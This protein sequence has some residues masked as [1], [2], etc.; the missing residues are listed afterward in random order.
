[1]VIASFFLYTF[2]AEV[3]KVYKYFNPNPCG[4]TVGD[5]VVRA[6]SAAFDISWERAFD[7][8]TENARQ[9]CDMPSSDSVWEATLRQMGFVHKTVPV[10]TTVKEISEEHPYGVCVAKTDGHVVS[11]VDGCVMDAFDSSNEFVQYFWTRDRERK[12]KHV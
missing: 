5:C 12:V 4:R 9:M 7:I 6:I 10:Y 3:K 1:M 11:I 2:F 8:L